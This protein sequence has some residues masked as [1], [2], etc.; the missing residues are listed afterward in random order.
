MKKKHLL[1][2]GVLAVLLSA[3]ATSTSDECCA[4]PNFVSIHE[5][6]PG[7]AHVVHRVVQVSACAACERFP[8]TARLSGECSH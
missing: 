3:C 5:S 1:I 6:T 2:I 8:V 7:C 4:S